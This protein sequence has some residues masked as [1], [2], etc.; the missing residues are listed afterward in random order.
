MGKSMPLAILM[1]MIT[2]VFV[3]W[4]NI[5]KYNTKLKARYDSYIKAAEEFEAKAIYGDAVAQYKLALDMDPDN[6][7]LAV[8]IKDLYLELNNQEEYLAACERAKSIDPTRSE[9]HLILINH[10][11]DQMSYDKAYAYLKE[12]REYFPDNEEIKSKIKELKGMYSFVGASFE[13][14][15]GWCYAE[16]GDGS[17]VIMEEDKQGMLN[18]GGS[19]L[20]QCLYEQAGPALNGVFPIHAEGELYFADMTGA[21]KIVPDTPVEFLG[22]LNNNMALAKRDGVYGYIN[23]K[24]ADVLF[25]F[26]DAGSFSNNVAPVKI[27]G[28]WYLVDTAFNIV[29]GLQFEDILRDEYGFCSVYGVFFGKIDGKYHLYDTKGNLLSGAYPQGFEDAKLFV[30]PQPAAVKMDGKWGFIRIDGSIFMEGKYEDADSYNFSYAPF[31]ESGKWGCISTT[32]ERWI[33]PI[34]DDMKAFARNGLAYVEM[35]G[36]KQFVVLKFYD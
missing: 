18:S 15:K 16:E 33:E 26:E 23:A 17:A 25:H 24:G 3:S 8:K 2:L 34:F 29:N 20:L 36:V 35:N 21:R 12:A 9:M 4:F 30:S 7:D 14:F 11:W 6:Y 10:Y 32:G 27:E 22:P 5:S 1:V 19:I 28:K 31:K 13:T